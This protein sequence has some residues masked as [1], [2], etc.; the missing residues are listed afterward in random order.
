MRRAHLLGDLRRWFFSSSYFDR[1]VARVASYLTMFVACLVLLGWSLNLSLLTEFF[2]GTIAMKANTAIGLLLAGLSLGLQTRRRYTLRTIRAA[3]G[4][5]IVVVIIACLTLCQYCFSWDLGID[6][7]LF[8]VRSDDAETVYPGRMGVNTAIILSLTGIALWLLSQPA[9]MTEQRRKMNRLI[10]AQLLAIVVGL[11]ALQALVGHAYQV[12][13]F[14]QLRP[15]MTGMAVHTALTFGS[16]AI[17]MLALR[18][19]HGIMRSL[20][21][22]L[23]GG[24]VARQFIPAAIVILVIL[25]WLILQGQKAGWYDPNFAVSLMVMTLVVASLVLVGRSAETLNQIELERKRSFDSVE[26]E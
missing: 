12:Q 20:T 15:L 16:L 22:P 11:I 17:G 1:R 8:R 6:Q 26:I 4:C 14:Y 3:Q 19:E 7:L 23:V 21:S 13:A 24:V 2:P 10:I 9:Q 18:S 5:A 25:G